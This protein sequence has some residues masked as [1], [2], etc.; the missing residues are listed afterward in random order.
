MIETGVIRARERWDPQAD[1]AC[2]SRSCCD[3]RTGELAGWG[4]RG[5]Q[6][7]KR[8]LK[9]D[10]GKSAPNSPGGCAFLCSI[11]GGEQ[12]QGA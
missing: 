2:G 6:E 3:E 9:V 5:E 11:W 7:Q 8:E 12:V 4:R 10:V 1:V